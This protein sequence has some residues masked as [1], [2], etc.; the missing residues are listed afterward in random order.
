MAQAIFRSKRLVIRMDWYSAIRLALG[1]FLI[2][3]AAAPVVAPDQQKLAAEINHRT[4][5]AAAAIKSATR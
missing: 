3:L 4:L 5:K 2:F 1:L